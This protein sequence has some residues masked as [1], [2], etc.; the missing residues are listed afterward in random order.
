MIHSNGGDGEDVV[1]SID[2][3]RNSFDSSRA[4]NEIDALQLFAGSIREVAQL[5]LLYI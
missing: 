3:M 4:V 5:F 2:L 1:S